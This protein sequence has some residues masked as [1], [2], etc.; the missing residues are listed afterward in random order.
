MFNI[1]PL[2]LYNFL[3]TIFK[4]I[5]KF[6]EFKEIN[7]NI[8]LGM[9]INDKDQNSLNKFYFIYFYAQLNDDAT[10]KSKLK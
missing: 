4:N 9:L 10:G 7:S 3:L 2:K 6:K 1:K 8:F 5:I